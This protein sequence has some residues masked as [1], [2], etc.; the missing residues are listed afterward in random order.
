MFKTPWTRPH[1]ITDHETVIMIFVNGEIN[2]LT[3][4][5]Y[6]ELTDLCLKLITLCLVF[7]LPIFIFQILSIIS[8]YI[9]F[10]LAYIDYF[11]SKVCAIFI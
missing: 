3:V 9:D 6:R 4:V 8:V 7:H 1:T 11:G 2:K 10:I 5:L